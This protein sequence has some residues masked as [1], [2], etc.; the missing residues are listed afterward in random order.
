MCVACWISR[1]QDS[2]PRQRF[3]TLEEFAAL[4]REACD[5]R[6]A[7]WNLPGEPFLHWPEFLVVAVNTGLRRA[8][9][10]NLEF[11]DIDFESQ[12]LRVRNKPKLGFHVKN[13][14]ERYI[15]L[16]TDACE[17]LLALRAAKSPITEFVFHKSNGGRW[18]D[19]SEGL[20][21]LVRRAK[22]DL[23]T[24]PVTL[25]TT[26]HTFGSWLALAGVPLRTIQKLMGHKSITTTERYAHLS[27]ENLASAVRTLEGFV[28][29]SVITQGGIEDSV[30]RPRTLH[31]GQLR[32]K[33]ALPATLVA[34]AGVV[35]LADA[36]DSK[37]RGVYAP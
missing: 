16:T 6:P 4:Q 11:A 33:M 28:I 7:S 14:Q 25:H 2:E 37:S 3:L 35:K 26:R 9:L 17:A 18:Q 10:L 13:Y 15:P 5:S 34:H 24:G 27:R 29:K 32:A 12:I 23:T 30:T 36:R 8:E 31:S 22:L 21:A 19:L 1:I 20:D